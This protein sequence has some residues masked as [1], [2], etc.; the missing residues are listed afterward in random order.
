MGRLVEN[1]FGYAA[2][3][4]LYYISHLLLAERIFGKRQLEKSVAS[5]MHTLGLEGIA[6]EASFGSNL[7]PETEMVGQGKWSM[8]LGKVF[9]TG[10]S[11]RH[12]LYHVH[13][14]NGEEWPGKPVST[15]RSWLIE[16]PLAE[17]YAVGLLKP[18][19]KQN[20]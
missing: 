9:A 2:I 11:V 13:R 16:E 19:A 4:G 14:H 1:V 15:A 6:I 12:E 17:L 3:I 7:F 20:L 10:A 18:G 8:R 5:E